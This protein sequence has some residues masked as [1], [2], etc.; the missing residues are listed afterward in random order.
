MQQQ[1]QVDTVIV[2]CKASLK[3]QWLRDGIEKFTSDE[4]IVI[5]GTKKQ[6]EKQYTEAIDN[7]Y[8][9]VI[10]NYELL[11]HD[12]NLIESLVKDKG[13]KLILADEAHK[14][15]NPKGKMN[16]LLKTLVQPLKKTKYPG[17]DYIFF[18]TATP[19]SSKVEQIYGLFSIRRPDMFGKFSEFAKNH[20]KYSFNGRHSELIGYR[21]LDEIREKTWKFM[22]RR[23][24]KEISMELPD[25]VEIF[26]DV[27]LTPLQVK[28]D[29]LA[30]AEL[31]SISMMLDTIDRANTP[32]EQIEALEG[33]A[34][35][36]F[37]VRKAAA[38]HPILFTRSQSPAIRKKFGDLVL[39]SPHKDKSP[40][41]DEMMD[42]VDQLVTEG[43]EK[44]IIFSEYET[45]VQVVREYLTKESIDHEIYTG[46][47]DTKEK[48]AAVTR[49]LS[50]T[51]CNI[52]VGTD[53]MAEGWTKV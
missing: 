28:I 52:L 9:Y 49:Y 19:L 43:G 41:M 22:L 13:V 25:I 33:T 14:L 3:Y 24:S 2:F 18:L 8:R 42:L 15:S 45:M 51:N 21:N 53:A 7:K 6:R 4:G 46:K 12:F 38:D 50:D 48:D 35:G 40:K 39:D 16:K 23:T 1:G 17:V 5:D 44:I 10:L 29:K 34:Q 36:M 26:L 47:M 31:E 37:Y 27:E 32:V 20:M 30:Q 11:L